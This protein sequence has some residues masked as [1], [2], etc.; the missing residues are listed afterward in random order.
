MILVLL[1]LDIGNSLLNQLSSM[2]Y[3]A[4]VTLIVVTYIVFLAIY[5]LATFLVCY[6]RYSDGRRR[7]KRYYG[8]LAKVS[9]G[10]S[11][12]DEIRGGEKL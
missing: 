4:T 1:V 3:F 9:K 10:C 12:E 8:H 2:D 6:L 7:L 11:R 5:L